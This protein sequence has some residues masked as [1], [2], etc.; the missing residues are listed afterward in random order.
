M[1]R[2]CDW[3]GKP[4]TIMTYRTLYENTEF[5]QTTRCFECDECASMP[6]EEL[7][8]IPRDRILTDE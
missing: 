5:E 6:T 4:A 7:L 3:C 1:T 2:H 8:N